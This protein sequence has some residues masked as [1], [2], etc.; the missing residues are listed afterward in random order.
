M[1]SYSENFE[2]ALINHCAS[3]IM[4]LLIARNCFTSEHFDVQ[5]GMMKQICHRRGA[6]F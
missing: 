1:H 3:K 2:F 6:F 4:A 5:F